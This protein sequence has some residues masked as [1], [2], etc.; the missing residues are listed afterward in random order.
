MNKGK[1]YIFGILPSYRVSRYS[2]HPLISL[3]AR[4]EKKQQSPELATPKNGRVQNF[5]E[6][7][8]GKLWTL[9]FLGVASSGLHFSHT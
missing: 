2:C 4:M 5:G 3:C 9:P 7:R 8:G 6:F 1:R